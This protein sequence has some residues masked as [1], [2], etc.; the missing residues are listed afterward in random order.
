M[1]L[2]INDDAETDHPRQKLATISTTMS[3]AQQPAQ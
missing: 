1:L 3:D 2:E